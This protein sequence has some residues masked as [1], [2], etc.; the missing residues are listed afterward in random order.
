M[1]LIFFCRRDES[2]DSGIASHDSTSEHHQLY[3]DSMLSRRPRQRSRHFE[4]VPTGRHKFEIRDL[5]DFSD[6]SVVVPLSLPKLPTNRRE[7]VT[8][9]LIRSTNSYNTDNETDMSISY[10]SNT[11]PASLI[12]T[13][14]AE[15]YEDEKARIDNSYSEKSLKVSRNRLLNVSSAKFLSQFQDAIIKEEVLSKNSSPASSKASWFGNANESMATK[16][17]SSISLSS[18]DEERKVVLKSFAKKDIDCD[19]D[20]LSSMTITADHTSYSASTTMKTSPSKDQKETVNDAFMRQQPPKMGSI[21]RKELFIQMDELKFA[22]TVDKVKDSAL[23]DDETSPTDSLVSSSDSGDVLMKKVVERVEDH[24]AMR[25]R[26]FDDIKE[27]DLEDITPELVDLVSPLTSPGTPTHA[28]NS[29]SLSEG[30][31]DDFLI[32]DEIADQP[33]LMFN[34]KKHTGSTSHLDDY[35]TA[36]MN[37]TSDTPTLRDINSH[38]SLRSLNKSQAQKFHLS[39][40]GN[41]KTLERSGSLDTLSPCDSIASDDM[42]GDFD[43]NSSLDSIDR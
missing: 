23:L 40:A 1:K 17:C 39:P 33:G 14:E 16:N 9:G 42:M 21:S 20:D 2:L 37:L 43:I 34:D 24:D 32:D 38:G 35:R 31:R 27:Q 13:S 26:Q 19:E 28:S 18:S 30:A 6:N 22:E 41:R 15:S 29:L 8:G 5:N 10:E 7:I 25:R 3:M 12:S 36:S 11:R 4:M